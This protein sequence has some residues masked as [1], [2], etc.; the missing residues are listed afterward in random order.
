MDNKKIGQFIL[1]LRKEK[2]WIHLKTQKR[3]RMDAA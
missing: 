3:K 1:K 2:G